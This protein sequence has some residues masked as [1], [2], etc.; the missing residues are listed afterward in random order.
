VSG[1]A[2]EPVVPLP[3]Q[4]AE[5]MREATDRLREQGWMVAPLTQAVV[6]TPPDNETAES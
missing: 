2:D 1:S 4:A 5:Q 3:E 6:P